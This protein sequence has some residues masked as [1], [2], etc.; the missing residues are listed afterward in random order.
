LL[1]EAAESREKEE[2]AARY[3]MSSLV[4]GHI[5]KKYSVIRIGTHHTCLGG[6]W[7]CFMFRIL[8]F[9]FCDLC[10]DPF[11]EYDPFD[12]L[13]PDPCIPRPASSP[14]SVRGR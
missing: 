10:F 7:N 13:R 11:H 8:Y 4:S 3:G 2:D 12:P 9:V 6:L 14:C 5:F 1:R